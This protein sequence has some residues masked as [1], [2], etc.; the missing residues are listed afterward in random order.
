MPRPNY[1]KARALM[2]LQ[3]YIEKARTF[4]GWTFDELDVVHLDETMPWD[5]EAIAHDAA[6]A[7]RSIVDLGTGGGERFGRIT[8]G[9]RGR[10]V[11][12]EEWVVN[13]PVARDLLRPLGVSVVRADSLRLPF[14][15]A[16]FDL[17]LDRHE[18]LEPAEVARVLAPGGAVV[19]QQMGHDVWPELQAF[20]PSVEFPDHFRL[21]QDGFQAAGLQIE[22]AQ[23]HEERVAFRKLGELVYMIMLTP[24]S[25]PDFDPVTQIDDVLEMEE[26]LRTPDGIVLTETHY[27]IQARKPA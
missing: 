16:A 27:I 9:A 4:S 19:T 14:A 15:D 23:Q 25:F 21:Y 13:A 3:P 24:H 6:L 17:V 18:A 7:A 26:E 2:E 1:V 22:Q 5:Y 10:L 11:A 12:T 8:D 20:F